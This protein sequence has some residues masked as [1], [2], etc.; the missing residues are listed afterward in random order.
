MQ[1]N[2]TDPGTNT[3]LPGV[4]VAVTGDPSAAFPITSAIGSSPQFALFVPKAAHPAVAAAAGAQ[5]LYDNVTDLGVTL[6]TADPTSAPLA[7]LIAAANTQGLVLSGSAFQVANT[8]P[9][10]NFP[11][12]LTLPPA[13]SGAA[14][15]HLSSGKPPAL[16]PGQFNGYLS[17]SLAVSLS[18]A[19]GY[20]AAMSP[21]TGLANGKGG[22]GISADGANQLWSVAFDGVAMALTRSDPSGAALSESTLPNADPDF[23]WNVLFDG[24][25]SAFAVGSA[26]APDGADVLAAYRAQADGT[27]VSSRTFDSG[28][29]NNNFVLGA[30]AP[31]WIV[32]GVQTSG[33]ISQSGNF[34]AAI[35]KFDTSSGL[36]QLTTAYS[37]AGNDLMTGVARDA[38]SNLWVAGFSLNPHPRS[39]RPYD[40]AVW[41][42]A[43][44]GATLLA[45]PF[46]R[47]GY[48]DAYDTSLLA[49]VVVTSATVYVTA[50]RGRGSGGT[51]IALVGLDA[52]SGRVIFE[53]A[54]RPSDPPVSFK[55]ST[56]LQD[57]SGNLVA[58]GGYVY[59]D[60]TISGIWRFGPSGTLVSAG[61]VAAG[62]AQG[63]AVDGSNLWLSVDGST[64][65]SPDSTET[66]ATVGP[67]D[68]LPPRTSLAAGA[69]SFGIDPIYASGSTRFGFASV[70]DAFTPGDGLGVGTTQTFYAI[71]SAPYSLF[72]S[73][74]Q[75]VAAGTHTISFYSLDSEGNAEAVKSSSVVVNLAPP[76]V[77]LSGAVVSS[78]TI[79]W[80]W[81][82]TNGPAGMT[83]LTST[84]ATVAAPSVLGPDASYY[85]EMGLAP[86]TNYAR[87]LEAQNGLSQAFS[88]TVTVGTPA[89]QSFATG[90][91]SGTV[92]G[93]DGQKELDIPIADLGANAQ[94]LLSEDPSNHPL[95][96]NAPALIAAAGLTLPLGLGGS[97]DS[98][99]EFIVAIDGSR[100]TATLP[101]PLTIKVPYPDANN[102][103]IVDGTS[104]PIRASTLKL[105][106]L[107]ENT[108]QWEAVPG[109]YADT[110]SHRVV[111]QIS[112]LSI[113]NAFGTG[114]KNDLSSLRVYPVPFKPNSG[115]PN[116]GS[117]YSAG[118]PNSGIVFDNLPAQVTIKIYT[119]TGRLVAELDSAGTNGAIQWDARNSNGQDVASGGYVAVIAS[120][121][122]NTKIVKKLLVIR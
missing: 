100:S 49:R 19:D 115:D 104:P 1:A 78:A 27:V 93:S 17:H 16:V 82:L 91:G 29:N 25:G 103:G 106:V 94:W 61:L 114:A 89:A 26:L 48:L 53:K 113:F 52:A 119:V 108:A 122:Q 69:P 83:L 42:Y 59:G 14:V 47:E 81:T 8:T 35:W 92:T 86:S 38:S 96:G 41:K 12:A 63:A 34:S 79:R 65:P 9:T 36:I 55:P 98:L 11:A 33:P 46:F 28:F 90:S 51:D 43:P 66:R 117:P 111:G 84:G 22:R 31:G 74:F 88:S 71:D 120:P 107:N 110:T 58:A 10:L 60:G 112:H 18:K 45:G 67:E 75:L 24:S 64:S 21:V 105:Y 76:A 32:G 13:P 95:I 54:G 68:V 77:V 72:T 70:D 39:P 30:A 15:Y 20:Y 109:S 3:L 99:T 40:L 5:L 116:Q 6:S 4:L 101:S 57:P 118:N 23:P 62:G 7:A 56:L 44:D 85:M 50:P 73:S 80:S 2:V 121:A 97:S 87:Y 102:D 37:R